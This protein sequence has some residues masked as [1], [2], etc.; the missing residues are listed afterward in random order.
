VTA[1]NLAQMK[2]RI[3][4]FLQ[5]V[6]GFPRYLFVFSLFK[7]RTLRWDRKEG[8]FLHFL[9]LLKPTD[10]VLDIGANVG[11]MTAKLAKRCPQGKVHA[12]EPIPENFS[13]LERIMLY[14][15]FKNVELHGYA[16]GETPGEIQMVMPEVKHVKMQGLSHVVH[17][18]ITEYNEGQMYSVPIRTLD[19]LAEHLGPVR[20]I[21]ID[22]E[23]FEYFVF[24]GG[25]ELLRQHKPMIYCELWDNE[26]RMRCFDF[27]CQEIGY[28]IQ[29]LVDGQLVDFDP[30]QHDN[31]NFFFV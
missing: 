22:A 27:L 19:E 8:D 3:Q 25:E 2:K 12:F 5:W 18:S 28:K 14:F 15:R 23:N 26:H 16:L 13:A 10:V 21:K 17:D 29:V 20:A 1:P 9:S 7:I 30:A 6:L 31:Q 4:R 24:R 11:I